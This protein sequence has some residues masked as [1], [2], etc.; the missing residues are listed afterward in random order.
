MHWLNWYITQFGVEE[1][2]RVENVSVNC[3]ILNGVVCAG[4]REFQDIV[5]CVRYIHALDHHLT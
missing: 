5:P 3:S 1:F 2:E 4:D